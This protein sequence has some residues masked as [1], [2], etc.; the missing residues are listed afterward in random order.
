[1]TASVVAT[2]PALEVVGGGEDG[3]AVGIDVKIFFS[4]FGIPFDDDTV[5]FSKD[6][7]GVIEFAGD[8]GHGFEAGTAEAGGLDGVGSEA[9]QDVAGDDDFLTPARAFIE[10]ALGDTALIVAIAKRA[11]LVATE[12]FRRRLLLRILRFHE[13][14][15]PW[16]W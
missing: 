3:V 14:I 7:L 2:V 13:E 1:M 6:R 16:A 8:A 15:T 12:A 10:M 4:G 11:T 9:S 5:D